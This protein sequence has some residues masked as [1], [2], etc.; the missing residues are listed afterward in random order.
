MS[1]GTRLD[2]RTTLKWV[3]AASATLA[4]HRYALAPAAA[5]PA[6]AEPP[7]G[8]A[9]VAA[10]GYGTDPRL[11]PVYNPGELWPLTM[12]AGQRR[13]AGALCDL[14][15]PADG[16]SP[17]ATAVGVVDFIDEW[18]S[19]PYPDQGAD[20]L[21]V[22]EGLAWLDAQALRQFGRGF[23]D[24]DATAHRVLCDPIC[25]LPKAA[26]ELREAA[27]FFARYRD[28]TAGGF[29]STDVGARDLGYVGNVA[30]ER[31]DGPPLEVLKHVGLA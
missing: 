14:I 5:A 23:A 4:T 15:I 17:G 26:P 16:V 27:R 9:P 29:Y 10:R 30:L 18:I 8:A 24:L 1:E 19:A 21:V 20:R 6:A 13:C 22:L 3:L 2:R 12:S 7:A 31:F 25:Y 28:L 11:I